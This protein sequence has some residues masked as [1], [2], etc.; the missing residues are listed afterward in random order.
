[1]NVA[2][3]DGAPAAAHVAAATA[4]LDRGHGKPTVS[5]DAKVEKVDSYRAFLEV[6]I[7][8]NSDLSVI[9]G[10]RAPANEMQRSL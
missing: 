2:M 4:V 5:V 6:L 9:N 10:N 7:E 3:D 1:M 8:I